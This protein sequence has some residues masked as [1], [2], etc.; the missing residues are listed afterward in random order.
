MLLAVSVGEFG[1][2]NEQLLLV[3]CG[4]LGFS[5]RLKVGRSREF[6]PKHRTTSWIGIHADPAVM[7]F[8]DRLGDWESEPH[9]FLL[10]GE[11]G[12]KDVR[13]EV[14]WNSVSRIGN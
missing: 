7:F 8:D 12:F 3:S 1:G 5:A 9:A 10:C 6:Y 2:T 11:E 4:N 14:G 13:Q